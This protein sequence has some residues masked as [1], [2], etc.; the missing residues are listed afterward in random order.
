VLFHGLLHLPGALKAGGENNEVARAERNCA[1]AGPVLYGY[2]A[3]QNKTGLGLCVVPVESTLFTGPY[4]PAFA[5]L[6]FLFDGFSDDNVFDC[7]HLR[8]LIFVNLIRYNLEQKVHKC[9]IFQVKLWSKRLFCGKFTGLVKEKRKIMTQQQLEQL[10]K[11]FYDYAAGFY[12]KDE[13][14]DDNIRLKED[15]TRRMCAD[16][17]LI[18]EGLGLDDEQ[19]RLAEITVLFHDVGRFKQF[20][21][22]RSYNDVGTENHSLLGLKV[23]AENKVLDCLSQREKEIIEEAI[24][25]HGE[26]ELPG[27][28][29]EE[30]ALFAKLVRDADKL[31]I[32]YVVI[33][34][35]GD[36]RKNPQKY[37]GT[38]GFSAE[39]KC[40]KHIIRAVLDDRTIDY[41]EFE[42]LNDMVIGQLGWVI[43]VNFVPT[44][45]EIKKRGLLEQMAAFLPDTEDIRKVVRHVW[46]QLEMRISQG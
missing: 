38:M 35:L 20:M 33:N 37:L 26:K 36:L 40:S 41:R 9:K 21:K 25:L 46:Q 1:A 14:T 12:G 18:A 30:T 32:Y 43:D 44:L 15:H 23:L 4:R 45:K 31:D 24:R 42:T 16:I 17:L 5:F 19:K 27:N 28:L 29:D 39:N 3:L 22:Y 11:W 10:K 2:P 7:R 6:Y 8:L 13:L 34:W